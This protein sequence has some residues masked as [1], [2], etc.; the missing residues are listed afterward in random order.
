M[1]RGL[2]RGAGARTERVIVEGELAVARA[3]AAGHRAE[4]VVASATAAARLDAL[5]LGDA[6]TL[7]LDETE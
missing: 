6:V 3:L 1:L 7:Q 4:L 2:P 5:A